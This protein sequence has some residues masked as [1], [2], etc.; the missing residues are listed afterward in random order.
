MPGTPN[1]CWGRDSHPPSHS[2]GERWCRNSGS[3]HPAR[4][5]LAECAL[6]LWSHTPDH[7][8]YASITWTGTL[9]QQH[10]VIEQ[11][12][13][14]SAKTCQCPSDALF[15]V[16]PEFVHCYQRGPLLRLTKAW[17]QT[18][19]SFS[20]RYLLGSSATDFKWLEPMEASW[21]RCLATS[22]DQK[23]QETPV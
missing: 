20:C 4:C 13:N 2:N 14:A 8:G 7:R 19:R 5:E 6:K 23:E 12:Q 11:K 21:W 9:T 17:A 10:V 1:A 18:E 15:I 16:C 3:K 22:V